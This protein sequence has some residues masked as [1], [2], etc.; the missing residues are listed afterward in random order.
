MKLEA[1]EIA[2]EPKKKFIV[3]PTETPFEYVEDELP[4]PFQSIRQRAIQG[5]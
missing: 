1:I 4:G 2:K 5:I 3:K